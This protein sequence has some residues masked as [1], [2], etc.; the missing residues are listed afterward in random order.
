MIIS[1]YPSVFAIGHKAIIDIFSLPVIIEEKIDGSQFSMMKKDGELFCRS[2]GTQLDIIN[3]ESMFKKAVEVAENLD[4]HDDW[5]YRCEYLSKP[6]HNTLVYARIPVKNLILF[7][8]EIS[9]SSFLKY[10]DKLKEASRIG[11][12]CVPLI[13]QGIIASINKFNELLDK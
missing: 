3:P 7:D 11:I 1:S 10:E 8:V 12:E 2:K 9:E 4:L 5:I 6:K 13:T